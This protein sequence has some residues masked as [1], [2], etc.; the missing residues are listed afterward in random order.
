MKR[1]LNLKLCLDMVKFVKEN[2]AIIANNLNQ[3]LYLNP[4]LL[5]NSLRFK[6]LQLVLL[7][8]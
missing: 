1:Y 2:F 7:P 5:T 4:M 3:N 6:M 8:T